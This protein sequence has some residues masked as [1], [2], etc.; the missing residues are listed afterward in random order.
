M[1]ALDHRNDCISNTVA[2]AC[3]YAGSHF[4]K[5]IDP[6]G[7]ILVSLYIAGTWFVTGYDQIVRLSGRSA[8]PAFVNRILQV[9]AVRL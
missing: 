1:L 2:I 7:A 6:L 4:W 9:R 8:E 3:A 5:Y